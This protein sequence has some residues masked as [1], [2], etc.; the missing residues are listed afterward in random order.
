VFYA[1]ITLAVVAL[2]VSVITGIW[3]L[4]AGKVFGTAAQY[5]EAFVWGF[6][7]DSSV[8]GFGAVMKRLTGP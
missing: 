7:I 3:V 6:G 2:I 5:I 8:R 1:D 4:W